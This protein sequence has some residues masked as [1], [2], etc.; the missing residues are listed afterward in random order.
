M[1]GIVSAG[2]DNRLWANLTSAE[3]TSIDV[4]DITP[5][6]FKIKHDGSSFNGECIYM[7]IRRPDGYV[8]KPPSAG[9]DVFTIDTGSNNFPAFDSNF[10]VDFVLQK[11]PDS[12]ANWLVPSRLTGSANYLKTNLNTAEASW[13][14]FDMDSNVGWGAASIWASATND[15]WMF[16]RGKGFDVVTWEG[17]NGNVER[18][19]NLGT[20]PEMIW[21]KNRDATRNWRTYHKGLNGG[22]NPED[23]EISL[24]ASSAEGA[25]TS[26]M[27]GTAPT[28][29]TFVAGNDDDTNGAGYS[30]IAL[31]F[32]SAN[33]AEGNPISKVG[34]YSGSSSSVT[35]T[36]GFQP[37]FVLIKRATGVGQWTM[38]D[39]YRGWASGNDQKLELSDNGAQSNSFD[40]G[41][42]TATG[43]TI[44]TGQSATNNNGDTYLYY[45]HA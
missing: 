38:F 42:P 43:F 44:T 37:R 34:S 21:F 36:T 29:T 5:T 3:S 9:T 24:N 41:E 18:R 32:A 4:V 39:T 12:T 11:A 2:N 40:Y 15:A 8:G 31:L 22:T 16:K 14:V 19:H 35:V 7:A 13:D 6:G 10:P 20:T 28:S 25:N 30:Y 26:Y 45:A 33:D 27:N 17:T 23:Y 1:R